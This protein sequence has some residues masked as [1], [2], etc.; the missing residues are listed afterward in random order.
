METPEKQFK[1]IDEY[2]DKIKLMLNIGRTDNA[3]V[4]ARQVRSE[5]T[6]LIELVYNQEREKQRVTK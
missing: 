5:L 2:M 4:L 3:M 6:N 1:I